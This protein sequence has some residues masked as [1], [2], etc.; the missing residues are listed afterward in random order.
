M[1]LSAETLSRLLATWPVARLATVT[2]AGRPHVVPIVFCALDGVIYSPL[3][4][5]RKRGVPL[6]RFANL[7]ANPEAV[8]LLD[9]YADD[10]EHLWWVRIDGQADRFV[11]GGQVADAIA[12]RLLGKYP[13]YGS[14]ELMFDPAVYLR[15]NPRKITAWSQSGSAASI[16][17]AVAQLRH[18]GDD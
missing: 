6:K 15:L 3:D 8:L 16:D 12:A 9:Q 2:R 18:D 5:K 4:G 10:W 13:Q 7:A 1:T 11:P 17:A 14:V